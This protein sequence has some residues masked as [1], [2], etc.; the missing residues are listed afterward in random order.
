M[1]KDD[2]LTPRLHLTYPSSNSPFRPCYL[3]PISTVFI[4]HH[5]RFHI[6]L[7]TLAYYPVAIFSFL[8]P[9]LVLSCQRPRCFRKFS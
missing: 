6:L 5:T 1:Q 8:H 2:D 3:F 4:H 7:S 9:A